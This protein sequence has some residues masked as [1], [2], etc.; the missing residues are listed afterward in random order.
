MFLFRKKK[1]KKKGRLP[2]QSTFFL[3]RK[4]EVSILLVILDHS[5]T[6]NR[7]INK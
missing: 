7:L 3:N 2:Y 5:P 6:T 1:N 4:K